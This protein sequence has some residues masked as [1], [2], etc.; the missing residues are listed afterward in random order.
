MAHFQHKILE[1][2]RKLNMINNNIEE[3]KSG[4]IAYEDKKNKNNN[5]I[6]RNNIE[7]KNYLKNN[8]NNDSINFFNKKTEKNSELNSISITNND[9]KTTYQ[10]KKSFCNINLMNNNINNIINNIPKNSHII[11]SKLNFDNESKNINYPYENNKNETPTFFRNTMN[12][13]NYKIDINNDNSNEYHT[14][15]NKYPNKKMKKMKSTSEIMKSISVIKRHKRLKKYLIEKNNNN[16]NINN[17]YSNHKKNAIDI[18]YNFSYNTQINQRI[19][20]KSIENP[21]I[22][23]YLNKGSLSYN[24][25]NKHKKNISSLSGN[26]SYN[27]KNIKMDKNNKNKYKQILL[28]I[29]NLTNQYNYGNNSPDINKINV[30][31]IL[32]EYKVFLYN[33]K[34]KDEII[35]KIINIYNKNNKLKLNFNFN[36]ID[37]LEPLFNWIK[38]N[39]D[40]KNENEEYKNLCLKIM[41]K[42]NLK[43]IEQFKI[44]IEKMLNKINNNENFLEGIK[45]ILLP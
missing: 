38:I 4:R 10:Y 43:N 33:N 6:F 15:K 7:K 31:N 16:K 35:F 39:T 20:N 36:N 26:K 44:F 8:N 19:Q 17:N 32:Y 3:I 34:I 1:M 40:S 18:D 27:N 11:N 22:R 37:S 41:K 2:Q 9:R 30:D 42:Y 29:I 12:C 28:E 45:K 21:K 14:T 23:N 25:K 13:K 5:D 24:N